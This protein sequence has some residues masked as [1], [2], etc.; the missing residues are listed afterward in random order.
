MFG[1]KEGESLKL[2]KHTNGTCN[3]SGPA[4]RALREKAGISQEQLAAKL[5][6]AE[7]NLNQKAVSRI[8]TGDRVVPDFELSYFATVLGVPVCTLLEYEK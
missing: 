7:L 1:I 2:Y 3:A 6:L 4:I 5:Q 8:E